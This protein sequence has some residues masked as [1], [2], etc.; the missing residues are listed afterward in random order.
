MQKPFCLVMPC[1]G[2]LLEEFR[3]A[4]LDQ[5]TDVDLLPAARKGGRGVEIWFGRLSKD[6]FVEELFREGLEFS[7]SSAR[8]QARVQ[9]RSRGQSGRRRSTLTDA[10]F[11]P[12]RLRS[13]A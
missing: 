2:Q 10:M 6:V 3:N 1:V 5:L 13:R 8:V 9:A 12:R 4:G 11:A 7:S